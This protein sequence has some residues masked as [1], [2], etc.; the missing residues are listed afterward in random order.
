MLSA[1]ILS[2]HS[3]AAMLLAEQQPYQRSVHSGPLVLGADLLKI[4]R[5]Q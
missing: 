5:L 1:L 2:R 4:Q 3:Y